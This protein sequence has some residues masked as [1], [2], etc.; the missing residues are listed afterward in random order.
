MKTTNTR[1]I[2][3]DTPKAL[4]FGK[5]LGRIYANSKDAEYPTLYFV[6][7][8][9]LLIND[10]FVP[11]E[12]ALA[13][14]RDFARGLGGNR[15]AAEKEIKRLEQALNAYGNAL[16]QIADEADHALHSDEP[17]RAL[18]DPITTDDLKTILKTARR[19]L[20]RKL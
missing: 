15:K 4:R 20:K 10:Q 8:A 1:Y 2:T 12:I 3:A 17:G 13:E 18:D 6:T 19:A 16:R 11:V 14:E 9:E 5:A 7:Q